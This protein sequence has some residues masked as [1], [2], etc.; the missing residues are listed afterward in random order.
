LSLLDGLAASQI[1]AKVIFCCLRISKIVAA[2]IL[3]KANF[4]MLQ[5]LK[6]VNFVSLL[7]SFSVFGISYSNFIGVIGEEIG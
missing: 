5:L 6:S 4:V 7:E 3:M 2:K 1:W